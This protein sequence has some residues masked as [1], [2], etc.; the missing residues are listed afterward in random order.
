MPRPGPLNPCF[1]GNTL[2]A[3]HSYFARGD[4][5]SDK[6][7]FNP[8]HCTGETGR[9]SNSENLLFIHGDIH[10]IHVIL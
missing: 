7:Y 10:Y 3:S 6:T 9:R 5:R 2:L 8:L 1:A 4:F